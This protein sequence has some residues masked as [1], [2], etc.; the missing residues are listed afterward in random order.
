MICKVDQW[1]DKALFTLTFQIMSSIAL[2]EKKNGELR[3]CVDYWQLNRKIVKDRY[4]LPLMKN[5]LDKLSEAT[6]YC[7]I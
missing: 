6:V 1:I 4:P 5:Q 7:C 3:L 2:V